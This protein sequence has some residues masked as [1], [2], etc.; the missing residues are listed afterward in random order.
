MLVSFVDGMG[1]PMYTYTMHRT[2]MYLTD[3]EI[4]RLDVIAAERGTTRSDLV[5]QA[6]AMAYGPMLPREERLAALWAAAGSWAERPGED[7]AAP[8]RAM[9]SAGAAKVRRLHG[10]D[11]AEPAGD[12]AEEPARDDAPNPG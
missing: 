6:I 2:Q 1:R 3:A 10:L 4:A 7:R 5:R 11:A 8:V 9:K 12:H